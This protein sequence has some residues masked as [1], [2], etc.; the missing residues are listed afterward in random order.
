VAGDHFATVE[1]ISKR[2]VAIHNSGGFGNRRLE[3]TFGGQDTAE[4]FGSP[5]TNRW[6]KS[7]RRNQD[8]PSFQQH[9]QTPQPSELTIFEFEWW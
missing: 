8:F 3:P 2:A 7:S 5:P 9:P 4:T 6:F 1:S